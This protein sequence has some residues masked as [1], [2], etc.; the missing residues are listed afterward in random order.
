VPGADLS[1]VLYRKAWILGRVVARRGGTLRGVVGCMLSTVPDVPQEYRWTREDG[2][3]A[4][5]VPGGTYVVRAIE[6]TDAEPTGFAPAESPPVA[7]AEGELKR[8]VVI[9]LPPGGKIQGVVVAAGSGQPVEGAE[10]RIVDPDTRLWGL[11]YL[12]K[13]CYSRTAAD[14]TFTLHDLPAGTFGLSA[15]SEEEGEGSAAGIRVG[16]GEI[17]EAR[18]VLKPKQ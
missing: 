15:K 5:E 2:E 4:V 9:E 11:T 1:V 12:Q 8:G 6:P 3:F 14:G 17:S 10:V 7:V 18:I 16:A 13:M